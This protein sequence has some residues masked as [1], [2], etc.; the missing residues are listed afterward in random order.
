MTPAGG[1]R[2]EKAI[3]K[4]ASGRSVVNRSPMAQRLGTA[5]RQPTIIREC[6]SRMTERYNH[7]SRARQ[8]R[9]ISRPDGSWLFNFKVPL[10]QV[11]GNGMGVV[12]VG[13]AL[14]LFAVF[15]FQASRGHQPSH[16]PTRA[17]PA[18]LAQFCVDSGHAVATFAGGVNLPDLG[19]QDRVLGRSRAGRPSLPGEVPT[20]GD[21]EYAAAG[22]RAHARLFCPR[23][24][25]PDGTLAGARR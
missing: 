24:S 10:Y 2:P 13:G 17:G 19:G 18:L 23:T 15:A 4:A 1:L 3:C 7:P 20:F 22:R 9:N 12:T 21:A 14:V 11:I 8:K 5:R 16:P 25:R 6:K